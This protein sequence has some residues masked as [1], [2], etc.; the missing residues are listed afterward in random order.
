MKIKNDIFLRYANKVYITEGDGASKS[1][2]TTE[3]GTILKNLEAYGYTFSPELIEVLLTHNRSKVIAFYQSIMV[4]IRKLTGAN[5]KFNPMYPNFPK[6][7]MDADESELYIN[8]IMHYLGDF[9]GLR[10]LPKYKKQKR[11]QLKWDGKIK[12][13]HL[14][15]PND[16]KDIFYNL[17]SSSASISDED[18]KNLIDFINTNIDN[19]DENSIPEIKHKEI[20]SLVVKPLVENE[21]Y[22]YNLTKTATDV[23]RIATALSDGDVS[24]AENTKYKNFKRKDRRYLLGLLD[25][26]NNIEEDMNRH[27]AKW[28]RLGER[29][30]PGEYKKRYPNAFKAFDILRNEKVRT[31]NSTI[32]TLLLEGKYET[33]SDL[34]TSR[35]GEF[36][37][38]LDNLVRSSSS[39][40]SIVKKF[41][42]VAA[43]VST[44]VLWQVRSH[45][46][47]RDN[48]NVRPVFPK[49][50]T[51]VV[52]AL[53]NNLPQL[54]DNL[55]DC[56]INACDK[57]LKQNY[58]KLEPMG[59]VFLDEKL[60]DYIVPFSQRSASKSLKTIVRGSS[61]PLNKKSNI[62][63]FFIWWK[64]QSPDCYEGRVD[65]DL[66]AAAF[67]SNWN[68]IS[69][70]SW[71][72]LKE[73][74]VVHSGDI[75]SAPKGAC[76][77]IDVDMS[78]S[79]GNYRYIVMTVYSYTRQKFI[80]LNECFA[81]WMERKKLGRSGEIF[82]AR[83]VKNKIDLASDS[84]A[85]MP[86]IIDT[87]ERKIVWA[88]LAYNGRIVEKSSDKM[89]LI[90]ESIINPC[91]TNLYDLFSMHVE[92]RNGCR[93]ENEEDADIV[94]SVEEGVTPFCIDE[95]VGK[96]I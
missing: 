65:L 60:V 37:R 84:T 36:A 13:V 44:P 58:S 33:A 19:I 32:E 25:N 54:N 17:M 64:D 1:S 52:K 38:R 96:Y 18:A 5:K 30:H 10:I 88:D 81:G 76:E 16:Y 66:S 93:V 46:I 2:V 12:V 31:F 49:G 21:K 77:F 69:H 23:L 20:L 86:L 14:G 94:F 51:S 70:V 56:I 78:K 22:C 90:G 29:L 45:F 95:I 8:A 53:P 39:P 92:A 91:K 61:I 75:T 50:K 3:V 73:A 79:P 6:Q 40:Y 68:F 59:N 63:R 82:D 74:S 71:T 67:D 35:P 27:K 80:D 43:K 7:V 41:Q 15:T 9:L 55:K 4:A 24:L 42:S 83:T 28:L 34:L 87:H 26:C 85:C 62:V 57:A 48:K 89:K 11:E 47:H 72:R